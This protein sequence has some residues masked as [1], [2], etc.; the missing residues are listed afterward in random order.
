M[1]LLVDLAEIENL[2]I[3]SRPLSKRHQCG[4]DVS[5]THFKM[6]LSEIAGID[7]ISED[8]F[9]D[10]YPELIQEVLKLI[11]HKHRANKISVDVI[12]D[13]VTRALRNEVSSKEKDA[14]G[15]SYQHAEIVACLKKSLETISR[16][17]N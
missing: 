4:T 5:G 17:V 3:S 1:Q 12:L 14:V 13:E 11:I 6:V 2:E 16:L 9:F 15:F 10:K 7:H 8:G